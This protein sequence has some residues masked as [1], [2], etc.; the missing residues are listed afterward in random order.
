MMT[1]RINSRAKGASGE[2]EAASWLFYNLKLDVMPERNLEQVR[3]GGGDLVGVG[4]FCV[5]V[6]RC[7]TLAIKKWWDQT[8]K[9]AEDRGEDPVLM[10]R[11][12]KDSWKFIVH[13]DLKIL[14][15]KDFRI[16]AKNRLEDIGYYNTLC[17]S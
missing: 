8:L 13:N 9:S 1:K 7:Q 14:A 10:F 11:K 12:N 2:R 6:K 3:S 17:A 5:E 4:C 15:E 16:F